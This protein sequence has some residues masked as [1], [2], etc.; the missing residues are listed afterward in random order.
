MKKYSASQKSWKLEKKIKNRPILSK[1]KK[2]VETGR[3]KTGTSLMP[4][5]KVHITMMYFI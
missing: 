2:E 5:N 1:N 4:T 3:W